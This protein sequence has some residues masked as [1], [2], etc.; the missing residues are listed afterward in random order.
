MSNNELIEKRVAEVH[1]T[2]DELVPEIAGL[3]GPDINAKLSTPEESAAEYIYRTYHE[4]LQV[5]EAISQFTPQDILAIQRARE[6]I[7]QAGLKSGSSSSITG[8]EVIQALDKRT[9]RDLLPELLKE[10]SDPFG[11]F[12]QNSL[13]ELGYKMALASMAAS[14]DLK[15]KPLDGESF[16]DSIIWGH[17]A[18]SREIE[19][20]KAQA[21]RDGR[22][23]SPDY[24][25]LVHFVFAHYIG[26]L[27]EE[28]LKTPEGVKQNPADAEIDRIVISKDGIVNLLGDAIRLLVAK[29]QCP[30]EIAQRWSTRRYEGGLG[31]HASKLKEGD[32]MIPRKPE[33]VDD[34]KQIYFIEAYLALTPV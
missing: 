27:A 22:S 19:A 13:Q 17:V 5:L 11:G 9:A 28:G 10:G 8:T 21:A 33:E 15:F 2:F 6:L 23:Y 25:G 4:Y 16:S 3:I 32:P 7:T 34:P 12:A 29:G 1:K 14:E 26:R 24:R 31:W 30:S 20:A 18:I